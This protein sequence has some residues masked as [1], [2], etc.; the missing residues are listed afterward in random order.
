VL[1]ITASPGRP[2]EA[3]P[4]SL[5]QCQFPPFPIPTLRTSSNPGI[6]LLWD[7]I[8]L[9]RLNVTSSRKPSLLSQTKRHFSLLSEPLHLAFT[10]LQQWLLRRSEEGQISQWVHG[11]QQVQLI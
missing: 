7:P 5:L 8:G 2:Q 6:L 11:S 9:P 10:A 4:L 3:R 1:L